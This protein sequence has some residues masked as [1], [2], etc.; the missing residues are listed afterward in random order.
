M[1]ANVRK[2]RFSDYQYLLK[3]D[4]FTGD[5]RIDMERG[6]LLVADLD[7][8]ACIGYAKLTS[9]EF[10]N[11]PLISIVNTHPE[12]R[13]I[14]VADIRNLANKAI[15]SD[16]AR[17]WGHGYCFLQQ[18]ICSRKYAVWEKDNE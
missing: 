17:S 9:Y 1:K 2:S 15:Q 10:F 16:S 8:K 13:G 3:F 18:K 11:K 6:E 5:R 4:E 14:G 12:Y 7:S